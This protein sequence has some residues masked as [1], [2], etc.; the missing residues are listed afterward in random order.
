MAQPSKAKMIKVHVDR[1]IKLD[2]KPHV[3]GDVVE[4]SEVRLANLTNK[5]TRL[6]D[7]LRKH[8]FAAK[9][10]EAAQKPAPKVPGK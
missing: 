3:R 6:D 1:D 2:K 9:L 5:V 10:Y 8:P 7:Y 4:V